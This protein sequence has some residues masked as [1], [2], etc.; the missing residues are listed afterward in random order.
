MDPSAL[1]HIEWAEMGQLLISLWVVVLFIVL[2][3]ANIIVGH[4]FLPSFVM[5]G[6]VPQYFHKVRIAFYAFAFICLAI[7]VFFFIRVVGQADVLKR[8]WPDYYI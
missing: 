4:N 5:S 1:G 2:F 7:A 3:A 6:H 8:F